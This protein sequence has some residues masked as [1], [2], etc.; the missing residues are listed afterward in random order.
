MVPCTSSLIP[1]IITE[2]HSTPIIEFHSTPIASELY[3]VGMRSKFE[4]ECDTCQR[5]KT[6]SAT[7]AG[8]LQ[9]NTLPLLVWEEITMDFIEGLPKVDGSSTIL[10]VVDHWSKYAHFICL[11]HPFSAQSVVA[12]FVTEIVR[13]HGVPSI[14]SRRGQICMS[15]FWKEIF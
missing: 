4:A 10:L 7:P 12:I 5:I 9:P 2:F 11:K 14:I 15:H 6:L 1:L 13:L 8:L 3:W